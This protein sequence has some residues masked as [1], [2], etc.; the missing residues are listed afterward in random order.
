MVV[1]V[2]RATNIQA[3][4]INTGPIIASTEPSLR[5]TH[6]GDQDKPGDEEEGN[7]MKFEKNIAEII[8]TITEYRT[9]RCLKEALDDRL[10]IFTVD[11]INI[12]KVD[13]EFKAIIVQSG[14]IVY[15]S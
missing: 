13:P 3:L 5:Q 11:L 6:H 1:D 15:E 2:L 10:G 8:R 7:L 14:V 4:V 9:E 12:D